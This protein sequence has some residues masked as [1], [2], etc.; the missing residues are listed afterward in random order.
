MRLWLRI[1][2]ATCLGVGLL[3][4]PLGAGQRRPRRSRS[5][6]RPTWRSARWRRTSRRA[7]LDT[8]PFKLSDYRG[9]IVVLDFWGDW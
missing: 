6:T 2:M 9:K 4:G 3:P 8:V 7:D 1:C 5:T